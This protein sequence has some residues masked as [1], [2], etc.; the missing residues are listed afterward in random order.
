M[1]Q[2][3][4]FITTSGSSTDVAV[5]DKMQS[6]A[7]GGTHHREQSMLMGHICFEKHERWQRKRITIWN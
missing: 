7:S 6:K 5:N 3:P 1:K 4:N 2:N